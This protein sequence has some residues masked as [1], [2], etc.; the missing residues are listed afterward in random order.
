M[1]KTKTLLKNK[2]IA[3]L[4]LIT[5]LNSSKYNQKHR[6]KFLFKKIGKKYAM[7]GETL[8]NAY[9]NFLNFGLFDLRTKNSNSIGGRSINVSFSA[10]TINKRKLLNSFKTRDFTSEEFGNLLHEYIFS[11]KGKI[12]EFLIEKQ[13][14]A[15]QW[16]K[17]LKDF[18]ISGKILGRKVLD[19]TKYSKLDIKALIAYAHQYHCKRYANRNYKKYRDIFKNKTNKTLY[20]RAMHVLDLYL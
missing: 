9:N 18:R 12:S 20:I 16:Y 1:T 10:N 4:E 7:S 11:Y 17:I 14:N 13:I 3:V 8:E 15:N 2:K 5:I 6:S 19:F